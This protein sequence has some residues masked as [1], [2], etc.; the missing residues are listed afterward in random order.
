MILP[1]ELAWLKNQNRPFFLYDPEILRKNSFQLRELW[2]SVS[3]KPFRLYYSV[4]ANPNPK[5]ARELSYHADG[6]DVSSLAEMRMVLALGIDPARISISGPAKS[7]AFLKAA[8]AAGVG[9]IHIDNDEELETLLALNPTCTRLSLRMA[10]PDL[11]TQKLG[12]SFTSLES[13]LGRLPSATLSGLHFY[14]GRESFSPNGL[15]EI[16]ELLDKTADIHTPALAQDFAF[17]VGAGI[18]ALSV[19]G[20]Q[21]SFRDLQ[22]CTKFPVHLEAGRAICATAGTYGAQ[23]LS[24]K[25]TGTRDACVLIEGGVQHLSTSLVS[26]AFGLEGVSVSAW[27]DG[28]Q[29]VSEESFSAA[30]YG[31]LCLSHDVIH[32][33]AVLPNGLRR[34]DWLL[35]NPAGAYGLTASANQFIG[36]VLPHEFLFRNGDLQEITPPSWRPYLGI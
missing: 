18:P 6:F 4:K 32:P 3:V 13:A 1:K 11:P 2:S 16:L 29:I 19:L 22:H 25:N 14:A 27:R 7:D 20:P 17:Y 36:Q 26:P 34:G 30:V 9:V 5:I 15:K 23:V 35:F 10:N 21:N 24:I 28:K 12:F 8:L 33:R 31:S